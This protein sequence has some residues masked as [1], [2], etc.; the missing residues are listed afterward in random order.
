[1]IL[2]P[3][4]VDSLSMLQQQFASARPFR[5]VE[6][7]QF[8]TA[9]F[10]QK[11]LDAFPGFEDEYA[12]NETGQVGR[13]A[14]RSDV[15][16]LGQVYQQLD[17]EL[18]S[19]MFLK[20]IETVTGISGLKYDPAY[21]GGGTHDNRSG[22]GLSPH[23]DFNFHPLDG[24]HRRLNL[25]VYLN[26]EW[27]ADW[28]GCLE[29]HENPWSLHQ[30]QITQVLPSLNHAILFETNEHSWHGFQ[31]IRQP[32]DGP[33]LARRS[34]ALYLYTDTRPEDETAI[35]HSTVYVPLHLPKSLQSDHADPL[36]RQEVT[37]ILENGLGMLKFLY[38]REKQFAARIDQLK[39]LQRLPLIGQALQVGRQ[40]GFDE[41]GWMGPVL[42]FEVKPVERINRVSLKLTI[43]SQVGEGQQLTLTVGNKSF[44]RRC[45]PN[46]SFEWTIQTALK[47]DK[48]CP[49]SLSAERQF[50]PAEHGLGEDRRMLAVLIRQ[51]DLTA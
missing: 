35:E 34:F 33:T 18:R 14:V 9:A 30:N 29:L 5:H 32:T 37:G 25:I 49:I 41:D 26:D 40:E 20:A 27:D 46:E 22:Q 45:E 10:C 28:G 24:R 1:M 39:G 21:V 12:R 17:D 3:D 23:V 31:T 44:E 7:D 8:F 11:M 36:V 51:I 6:I 19:E 2:N 48:I 13:K 43:P 47:K 42:R 4:W 16:N 50:I 38:D 15:R